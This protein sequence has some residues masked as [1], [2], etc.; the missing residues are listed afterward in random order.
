MQT[1]V[2]EFFVKEDGHVLHKNVLVAGTVATGQSS[3][4]C[5]SR[6]ISQRLMRR[7]TMHVVMYLTTSNGVTMMKFVYRV[8]TPTEEVGGMTAYNGC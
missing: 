1:H 8:N 3:L 2:V 4:Q 6:L 5:Y 7:T